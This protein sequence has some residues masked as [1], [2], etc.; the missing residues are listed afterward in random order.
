MQES[1]DRLA[2]PRSLA[3][4]AI[5]RKSQAMVSDEKVHSLS[6]GERTRILGDNFDYFVFECHEPR[7]RRKVSSVDLVNAR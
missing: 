5:S 4:V 2:R 3:V 1:R 7:T 6:H